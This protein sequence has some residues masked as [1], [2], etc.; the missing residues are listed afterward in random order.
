MVGLNESILTASQA[1]HMVHFI[2]YKDLTS[3]RFKLLEL[4]I[5]DLERTNQYCSTTAKC[6]SLRP[7]QLQ[8]LMGHNIMKYSSLT[9]REH[10]AYKARAPASTLNK[11]ID[12]THIEPV[13]APDWENEQQ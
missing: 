9:V 10:D 8:I 2:G 3:I 6:E 4:H 5:V 11:K 7:I 13:I 12:A 1:E